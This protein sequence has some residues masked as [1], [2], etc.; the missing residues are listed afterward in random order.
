MAC[1][2]AN[3]GTDIAIDFTLSSGDFTIEAETEL[4]IAYYVTVHAST[5]ITPTSGITYTLELQLPS[6]VSSVSRLYGTDF[7][8]AG[9]R[10]IFCKS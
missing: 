6:L 5:P 7:E 9:S 2:Y 4:I 3:S 10:P 1:T 8:S